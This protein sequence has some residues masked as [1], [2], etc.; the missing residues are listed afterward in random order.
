M[1]SSSSQPQQEILLT[2]EEDRLT[3]FPL[4]YPKIWEQYKAALSAIWTVEEINLSSDIDDWNNLTDN[5]RHF[6]KH[7]LAFFSSSDTIVNINLS[8]RFVNEVKPLEAKFF[9]SFQ[10]SIENIHCVSGDTM[11][12]TNRGYKIIQ[13][14]LDKDVNVWNGVEFAPTTVR[15][16]GDSELIR[17]ELSNGLKLDC[18][19]EH[20]WFLQKDGD[21][22]KTI[23]FTKDLMIGQHV[24]SY[25]VPVVKSTDDLEDI[26]QDILINPY[27]HGF[28]CGIGTSS[29]GQ[30][31]V[32]L[33][34]EHKH[35][36]E[37]F[38]EKSSW[39]SSNNDTYGVYITNKI[40][41]SKEYVP[42]NEDLNTKLCWLSGLLDSC[43]GVEGQ[44]KT[45][46]VDVKTERFGTD[47]MLMLT[48]MGIVG[49]LSKSHESNMWRVQLD[50]TDVGHL[51]GLGLQTKVLQLPN[52]N[53]CVARHVSIKSITLLDGVHRTYCF[54]EPK[55]HAGIFNGIL[56]GQ[57][58][59]YSLL[60]D[61]Y[62]K[63][64]KEKMQTFNAIEHIP[65]IKRKAD[66]CFKW[67]NDHESGFAQRLIAFAIVEGVFFSGAFCSIFWLKERGKMPGLCF[68]NELISRDE[69]MHVEF[70]VL[71]YSMIK[72]RVSQETVHDMFKDAVEVEKNFIIDSIPCALLGMNAD[73]MSS[74]IEY[75]AD[76]LLKQL[77]Y[78]P[79]FNSHNPFP[80]M[81]RIS[82]ETKSNFFENRVAEYS[83]ANVG[84]NIDHDKI[85]EFSMDADF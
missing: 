71:L 63:D 44:N 18:T 85:H 59:T 84:G 55:E 17:V 43:G 42:I 62:I 31:M 76:R 51:L 82:I 53:S 38:G 10:Q 3:I 41:K 25:T 11:I 56:T 66:W 26:E 79:M 47:V 20:K 50:S 6:I 14:L 24:F 46:K 30:P 1:S 78:E 77:D 37:T 22:K 65:C 5:E 73:L 39:Y 45:T 34:K 2:D 52:A 16:T 19:P 27:I 15:Y 32:S 60:I 21:D 36:L 81:E 72:N 57:S 58:E 7:I 75:V 69:S 23:T 13:D 29:L 40:N 4:K 12:L 28:Y 70:A 48:T 61:T 83:K 74:Y 68:S 67:I 9:Y 49:N 8:E 64:R 80:F 35:L 54:N 33:K